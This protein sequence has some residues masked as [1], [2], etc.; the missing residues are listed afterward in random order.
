MEDKDKTKQDYINDCFVILSTDLMHL[1]SVICIDPARTEK[2][3]Q[4]AAYLHDHIGNM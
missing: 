1:L 2:E 4:H 3:K